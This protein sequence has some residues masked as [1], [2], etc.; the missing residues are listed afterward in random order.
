MRTAVSALGDAAFLL[1]LLV[2]FCLYLCAARRFGLARDVAGAAAL[3]LGATVASKLVFRAC[4]HEIEG[5]GLT[6]PSGHAA[7]A[8]IAYGSLA[9]AFGIGR[10]R[11]LRIGL[12]A[13]AA[14]LALAVGL[15]RIRP[16]VHTPSEVAA[17]LVLGAAAVALLLR[18]RAGRDTRPLSPLPPLAGAAILAGLLLGHSLT[19]ERQIARTARVIAATFDVCEPATP[20]SVGVAPRPPG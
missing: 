2:S 7:F 9:Y 19:F 11:A 1:P 5:S 8:A 17:G 20:G 3:G 6:S 12:A 16:N 4:G 14:L 15:S 10:P 13:G 18:L